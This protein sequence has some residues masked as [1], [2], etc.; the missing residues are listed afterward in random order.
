MPEL[1]GAYSRLVSRELLRR[2]SGQHLGLVPL[3]GG[4]RRGRP[5]GE[6][7]TR[8]GAVSEMTATEDRAV[9]GRAEF[10][11]ILVAVD[12][13]PFSEACSTASGAIEMRDDEQHRDEAV[14]VRATS[15]TCRERSFDELP[16]CVG[17]SA[18]RAAVQP[19]GH[20]P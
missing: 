11:K 14:R 15:C 2:G 20:V 6:P 1:T 10:R 19:A 18:D 9:E 8:T 17:R 13:S 3:R 16:G 7:G 4:Q 12:N 5:D